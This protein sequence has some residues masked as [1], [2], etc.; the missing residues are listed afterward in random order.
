ML[1]LKKTGTVKHLSDKFRIHNDLKQGDTLS[2]FILL[3]AI[4]KGQNDI[5]VLKLNGKYRLLV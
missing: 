3:C 4:M 2:P 5:E 1:K